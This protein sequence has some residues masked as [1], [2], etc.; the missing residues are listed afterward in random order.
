MLR[1]SLNVLIFSSEGDGPPKDPGGSALVPGPYRLRVGSWNT[2][3]N[4]GSWT[5]IGPP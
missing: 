2:P 3:F 1:G 4:E 5:D